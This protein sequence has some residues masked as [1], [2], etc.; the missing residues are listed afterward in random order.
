[1]LMAIRSLAASAAMFGVVCV[2]CADLIVDGTRDIEYGNAVA[3]QTVN[4]MFGD[5]LGELNA[6]FARVTGGKLY[7]LLTGNLQSN[8][9]TIDVFLDTRPGG[10]NHIFGNNLPVADNRQLDNY[11]G[12][13]FDNGFHADTLIFVRRLAG[14]FEL[15]IV[16]MTNGPAGAF[17]AYTDLFIGSSSGSGVTG[18]TPGAN[19]HPIG[20]AYDG[21]NISGVVDGTDAANQNAAL[22]VATGVELSIDLSDLGISGANFKI[23]VMLNS[24]GHNF[25]SN[26]TLSGL[27]PGTGL[28]GGDGG[29]AFIGDLTGLD[30]TDYAGDQ[31]FTVLLPA[32][33]PADSVTSATFLPPGDGIV[34]GADLA[35]LLGAWGRNPGSPAD[36]VSSNT[37]AP[38]PDGIVNGADLA[39]LLGA[40]GLCP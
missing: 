14:S 27:P 25:V 2:S 26:Q 18:T 29:G 17:A 19:A 10:V 23:A 9:S 4:T 11:N 37:F 3:I 22:A 40:W 12:L 30:F 8:G 1:M 13:T 35:F 20:V 33:C 5:N 31:F 34:N 15:H 24:E 6:A 38:P 28:L 36:I 21:S 7:L 32:P 39:V 16:D